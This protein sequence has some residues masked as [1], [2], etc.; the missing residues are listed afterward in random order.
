MVCC[1][2]TVTAQE[3]PPKPKISNA[4]VQQLSASAGLKATVD[5]VVQKQTA[6][7]WIGYRV[8]TAAKER[9][10]CCFDSADQFQNSSAAAWAAAWSLK[11]AAHLVGQARTV[12]NQKLY[13]MPLFSFARK[14]NRSRSSGFTA[15]TARSTL[16]IFLFIGWKM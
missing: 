16:P 8:P 9:T 15:Q 11:R 14:T 4:K 5:G 12:P 10:M 1:A 2:A 13:R 3:A 7:L 6:P